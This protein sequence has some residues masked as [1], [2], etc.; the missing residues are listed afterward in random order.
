MDVS[1]VLIWEAG[2][3]AINTDQSWA[4]TLDNFVVL[5]AGDTAFELDGPEGTLEA[6]HT[7][8]NGS[9]VAS[10][11]ELIDLD[12][13]SLVTL[14]NIF[15]TGISAG[16]VIES[17]DASGVTFSNILLDVS[18][19][20]LNYVGDASEDP[21]TA[22]PTGISAGTTSQ[23]NTAEFSFTWASQDAGSGFAGL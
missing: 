17:A 19:D 11:N 10:A 8:R 2:D 21:L 1:N 5:R 6:A 15:I 22:V 16:Q 12:D 9:V 23:A 14:E 20:V 18:D 3:D 7:I 4:G 13:N